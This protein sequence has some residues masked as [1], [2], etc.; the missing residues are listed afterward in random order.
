MSK[1]AKLIILILFLL[2]GA[3]IFVIFSTLSQ[4]QS[5]EKAKK[6][7]ED[8]VLKGETLAKNLTGEKVSLEKAKTD[9]EDQLN[10]IQATKSKLEKDVEKLNSQVKSF[11]VQIKDLMREK[12]EWK[13]RV[14]SIK[15]ERDDLMTRI[16]DKEKELAKKNLEISTLNQTISQQTAQQPAQTGA[17]VPVPS[18][19]TSAAAQTSPSGNQ[20]NNESESYLAQVLKEKANLE[21]QISDLKNKLNSSSLNVVELKNKLDNV[22]VELNGLKSEK[23]D[24]ENKVK[25][26][27]DLANTLSIDLA[28]SKNDKK[29]V[30]DRVEQLRLDNTDLRGQIKNLTNTKMALEKSVVQLTDQK[31]NIEKKLA[32]TESVIQGRINEI[33]E[34]KDSLDKPAFKEKLDELSQLQSSIATKYKSSEDTKEIEL[35][36]I[37]VSAGGSYAGKMPQ[38]VEENGG[39]SGL[40]GRIVSI[41]EENNFAIVDL[42]EDSGV[43]IGDTL[44]VYRDTE[45]I[46]TLSIIQ[47]RKDVSAADIIKLSAKLK[48][49]DTVQ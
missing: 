49:G 41:N 6:D 44:N 33:L 17:Y 22:E 40:N 20:S 12:D 16:Q 21:V 46:A 48:V 11:D 3:S 42:G 18:A 28:R 38:A 31:N 4:K 45:V 15:K 34:M 27:E 43:Q 5:L 9:L 47:V 7:L 14:D 35:P 10:E 8:Q 26:N 24:I 36:P 29:G 19:A 32:E 23:I 1:V 13:G 30:S 25:Y 37:V 2:L 39:A